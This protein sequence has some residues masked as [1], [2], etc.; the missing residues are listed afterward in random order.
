MSLIAE[1]PF[2]FTDIFPW[3]FVWV[4]VCFTGD[5][6][7]E[8]RR[9]LASK[10]WQTV[11][12]IVVLAR[13]EEI[14]VGDETSRTAFAPVIEYRYTLGGV[15]RVS[16]KVALSPIHLGSR[17]SAEAVILRYKVGSPVR[18]YCSP[19]DPEG[20]ILEPGVRWPFVGK[21]L[22]GLMLLAAGLAM[23]WVFRAAGKSG[24]PL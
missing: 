11:E 22:F 10:R 8:I 19:H 9:A 20:A 17:E 24:V 15:A 2:L 4:G 7:Q 23:L 3:V 14:E 18:V 12:G 21:M 1:I 13:L 5:A 6:V 16:R